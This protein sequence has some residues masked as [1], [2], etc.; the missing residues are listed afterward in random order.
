MREHQGCSEPGI[1]RNHHRQVFFIN[2]LRSEAAPIA[3]ED[4]FDASEDM[5]LQ[6]NNDMGLDWQG[7][8]VIKD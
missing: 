4:V 6:V 8:N 1:R 2:E 3:E 7:L 5:D